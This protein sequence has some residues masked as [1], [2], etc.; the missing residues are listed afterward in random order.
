MKLSLSEMQLDLH[1]RQLCQVSG[2]LL[3]VELRRCP[4]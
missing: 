4:L 1:L 3:N 2:N